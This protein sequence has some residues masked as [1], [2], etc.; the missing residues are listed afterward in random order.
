MDV[1]N[2]FESMTKK[3]IGIKFRVL[4]ICNINGNM[5][6]YINTCMHCILAYIHLH[7]RTWEVF[8]DKEDT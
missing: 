1:H 7:G 5:H 2:I 8:L 4:V 6:A 3:V